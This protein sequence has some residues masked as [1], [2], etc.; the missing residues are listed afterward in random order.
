MPKADPR[1]AG[2]R[3]VQRVLA[4]QT[5]DTAFER[6]TVGLEPRDRAF[7]RELSTGIVR[8]YFS[9]SA[10]VARFTRRPL[11]EIDTDVL[12][13]LLVGAYQIR[14]MRVP[15]FAAVHATVELAR[16]TPAKAAGGLVNAVLRKV[17]NTPPG[18]PADEE[19]RHDHP[20]WLIDALR[21]AYPEQWAGILQTSLG[22]SPL[23]VRVNRRVTTRDDYLQ[24][25]SAR[26]IAAGPTQASADGV[27]FEVPLEAAAIPGLEEGACSIQDESAQLAVPALRL[28]DGM[29]VLDA[30]AAPGNKTSHILDLGLRDLSL[31]VTD[32]DARR[33]ALTRQ[34]LLRLGHDVDVRVA[35]ASV[36]ETWWEGEPFD[37]ILLDAP[38]SGTGTLRRHPDIKLLREP[39]DVQRLVGI[40]RA[41]LDGAWTM[42]APG[43]ELLYSTCSLLPQENMHVVEQFARLADDVTLEPLDVAPYMAYGMLLPVPEGPDGFFM[44]RLRKRR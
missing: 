36:P 30:C 37:R 6:S 41:L 26:G 22:R 13:L 9:L 12:I 35:D 1:L 16:A 7:A 43:G 31:T 39:E 19:A 40:Q 27:Q 34:A 24:M 38:C 33:A 11:A 20:Q 29:R 42:L 3:I 10:D 4:G 14:Y 32:I 28:G 15:G 2:F 21:A 44:V 18:A 5:L 8:R 23:T 17:A 25:L